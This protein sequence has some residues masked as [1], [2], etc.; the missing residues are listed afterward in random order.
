MTQNDNIIV[1]IDE[2][3]NELSFEYLDTIEYDGSEYVVLTPADSADDEEL[4]VEILRIES[5]D[6]E[7]SFVVEEDEEKLQAV[8]E[9]FK[10]RYDEEFD[11]EMDE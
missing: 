9:I 6:E 3:G 2:E 7:D 1:L 10:Q 4:R 5:T 8:F 11:E